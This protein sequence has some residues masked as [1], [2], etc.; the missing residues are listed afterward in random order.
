M[1]SFANTLFKAMLGWLQGAASAVWSAFT[2]ENGASFLTWIGRNWMLVAGILC[3]T[4]LLADLC[5]YLFRWRPYKVW[6]SFFTRHRVEDTEEEEP[7][8]KK[9]APIRQTV[10]EAPRTSGNRDAHVPPRRNVPERTEEPDLSYWKEEPEMRTEPEPELYAKPATVTKSGYV[11]PA[12]SPYRRPAESGKPIPADVPEPEPVQAYPE[13]DTA[14]SPVAPRRRRR[15]RVS[16]LF[17]DPEEEV[18]EFDAPQH[19]IDAR[20]AYHEPVY[21]RGWKKSEDDGE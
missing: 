12:D 11:V 5:V 1:G 14:A 19:V 10:T 2:S 9:P 8:E 3:V 21:P 13:E 4:G 15:L 6:K 20:R 16:E 17:N 7:E 18:Q